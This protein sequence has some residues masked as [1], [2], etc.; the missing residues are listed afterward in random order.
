MK[1]LSAIILFVTLTLLLGCESSSPAPPAELPMVSV[2]AEGTTFEPAVRKTQIPDGAWICNMGTVH[3][4][5]SEKGDGK[6]PRCSMPLEA[7]SAAK[8]EVSPK[9]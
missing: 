3:Y 2:S 1:S 9:R 5:R 7:Y 6:C 4:A 8:K